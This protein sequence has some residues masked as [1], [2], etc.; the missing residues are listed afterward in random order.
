[1]SLTGKLLGDYAP[2]IYN[3]VYDID[4]RMLFIECI[5]DPDTKQP[6][7]RIVFPE[8]IS[9]SETNEQSQ[10]DDEYIDDIVSIN[11]IEKGKIA[12]HTYKK[13]IEITLTGKPFTEDI[14]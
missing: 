4:V 11:E 8:I 1:M 9:Y 7:L 12:I 14:D 5:D 13:K 10:P 3:L 6:D 2:Y